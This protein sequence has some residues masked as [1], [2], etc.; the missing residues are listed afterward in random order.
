ME[1]T[2]I[3]TVSLDYCF[4]SGGDDEGQAGERL[5]LIVVD[6][7]PGAMHELPIEKKRKYSLGRQVGGGQT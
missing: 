5:V 6:G 7:K 2:G 1:E 4:V 3:T